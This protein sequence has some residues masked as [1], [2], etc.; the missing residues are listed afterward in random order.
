MI[1]DIIRPDSFAVPGL[2]LNTLNQ[3]RKYSKSTGFFNQEVKNK[4]PLTVQERARSLGINPD[5]IKETIDTSAGEAGWNVELGSNGYL[6]R[7]TLHIEE[8]FEEGSGFIWPSRIFFLPTEAFKDGSPLELPV[9]IKEMG[10]ELLLNNQNQNENMAVNIGIDSLCL[11]A[12]THGGHRSSGGSNELGCDCKGQLDVRKGVIQNYG[13]IEIVALGQEGRGNGIKAHAGQ[14]HMQNSAHLNGESIP[15][16]YSAVEAQGYPRDARV[17]WHWIPAILLKEGFNI[18]SINL[19]T[20]NGEK[21]EPFHEMGLQADKQSIIDQSNPGYYQGPNFR[22]KVEK[23]GHTDISLGTENE[24]KHNIGSRQ[25]AIDRINNAKSEGDLKLA[26][27]LDRDDTIVWTALKHAA[28]IRQ[29]LISF[30]GYKLEELPTDEEVVRLGNTDLAFRDIPEYSNLIDINRA[31]RRFNRQ[32]ELVQNDVPQILEQAKEKGY[33]PALCLTATPEDL[34]DAVEEGLDESL[35]Q[36]IPTIGKPNSVDLK[37]TAQWK[38][39]ELKKLADATTG[40][41][42]VI[43]D[44]SL[45]LSKA[46]NELNDPRI[47]CV[48]LTGT[49]TQEANHGSLYSSWDNMLSTLSQ[50]EKEVEIQHV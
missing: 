13:G 34:A 38:I 16:T 40:V 35:G 43:I 23:G 47:K 10:Y 28:V 45:S 32:I 42:I 46:I 18:K 17:E 11:T 24:S 49:L 30:Y 12:M 15:D 31:S 44:D 4:V 6:L 19:L 25:E 36:R 33:L 50:I 41:T 1:E 5:I 8:G 21:L 3:E 9:M 27:V 7:G 29:A 22:A 48:T 39:T 14:I 37:H 2:A 20:N 26:I